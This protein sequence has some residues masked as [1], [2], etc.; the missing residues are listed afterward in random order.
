MARREGAERVLILGVVRELTKGIV[1]SL[2][3]RQAFLFGSY[4]GG[5]P[6]M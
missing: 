5:G 4:P 2:P 1:L 3:Q 6:R